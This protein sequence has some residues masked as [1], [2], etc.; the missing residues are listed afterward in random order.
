MPSVAGLACSCCLIF[1]AAAFVQSTPPAQAPA[2]ASQ[3]GTV[4]HTQATV[5]TVPTVV[6]DSD[7][8]HIWALQA[9]DF[10]I[11]DNGVPQKVQLDDSPLP[12]LRAIA[13]VVQENDDTFLL[14]DSLDAALIDFL[15][16]LPEGEIPIEVVTAGTKAK[17]Y[18]PFNTN[19]DEVQL[20]LRKLQPDADSG[21]P[22]LLDG[23]YLASQALIEKYPERQKI[24]LLVSGAHDGDSGGRVMSALPG[25]KA[26]KAR[27]ERWNSAHSSEEVLQYVEANNVVVDAIEFSRYGLGASDYWK[28]TDLSTVSLNPISL[29]FHAGDWLRKDVPRHLALATG[30]EVRNVARK[31]GVSTGALRIAAD[32]S[33]A[34]D[35]S[36]HPTDHTPGLHQ[37][38]VT[39]P[40]RDKLHVRSRT[41]YW[42]QGVSGNRD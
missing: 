20:Q 4:F 6:T 19:R 37:I 26:P 16:A 3:T 25:A 17:I 7:G 42:A 35:L 33:A 29:L 31:R 15:N 8:N 2:Q 12:P 27:R 24:V 34:Y 18:Q 21:G 10:S 28:N 38:R 23:V 13:I 22:K 39:T 41:F 5:V 11:T 9:D 14:E 32:F 36:F 1:A 40:G 30:G